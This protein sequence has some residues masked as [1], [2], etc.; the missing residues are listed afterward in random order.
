MAPFIANIS[1]N[2]NITTLGSIN[3]RAQPSTATGVAVLFQARIGS[4]G[5]TILD[6]Q[7]D[8]SNNHLNGKVY[9]W[10]RL[11]FTD[12]QLG[13]ARDDLIS[14]EGDGS[15]FGYPVLTQASYAFG[16]LRALLPVT[17]APTPV[18][19]PPPPPPVP[20]PP[21]TPAPTPPTTD[22]LA[23]V[24][25][26]AGLNMR[27][28]PVNGAIKA[29]IGYRKRVKILATRPQGGTSNYTW[30]QVQAVEGI[31]WMRTDYLSIAGDGT[32]FG[33]SKGDEYPAPMENYWW[34]RGQNENQNPGEGS[35]KGWDFSASPNEVIRCAPNGGFAIRV[36]I[37]TR[38]TVNQPNVLSQGIPL[39]NAGV[40]NDPAWGYG[41]GNAVIVRYMNDQLPA[42]ARARLAAKGMTGAHLYAIYGHLKSV[43]LQ[44]GQV[45][46]PFQEIGIIGNSGN[47]SA[48]HLHLEVRASLNPADNNW[49]GMRLFDPEVTF[50]R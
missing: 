45:L 49:A 22:V 1:G 10:F 17:P 47:S 35:H 9:Q 20:E 13:W 4:N 28:A 37:C 41:Y 18:P 7:P 36:I 27:E 15:V 34:V 46:A 43:S 23:T 31:G 42:S 39:D 5:L 19:P 48:L 32:R 26:V 50:L 33:L 12:G 2:P 11:R 14:I 30:A 8:Q 40:F 38:C 24:L 29:R 16:L 3:V 25:S 6:V 44:A 21:P